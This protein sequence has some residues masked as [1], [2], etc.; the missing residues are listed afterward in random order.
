MSDLG[1]LSQCLVDSDSEARVR[2]RR[3]RGKALVLSVV[4]ECVLVAAMLLWPLVSPD[5]LHARY[6]VMPTPPYSGG[7][8]SH[9]PHPVS[10]HPNT[11]PLPPL[12]LAVCAP[13]ARPNALASDLQPPD[14][15]D[16]GGGGIGP[17]GPG[18]IGLGVPGGPGDRVI[19]PE[20][21]HT[22]AP[23]SKP[24]LRSGDLMAAM[25]IHEV[26][27][28]YPAIAKAAHISGVVHLHA[29]IRTDGTVR[30]LEAV[31]GNVLLAQAAIAAVRNWRYRP[32]L[33]SGEAVEVETYI[34]VK[35]VL[36]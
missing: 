23:P 11:S 9:R 15:D 21:P 13:V 14:I 18:V 35:F 8:G 28:V 27:P 5:V 30:A 2:A 7:G 34:T 33:L 3:L 19:V 36:N 32:T 20:P 25:L 17:A 10:L 22:V 24:A 31:D 16:T 26:D 12:C 29:F 4:F 1:S 6:N